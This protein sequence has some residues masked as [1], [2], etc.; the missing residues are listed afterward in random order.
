MTGVSRYHDEEVALQT[1]LLILAKQLSA[2]SISCSVL[3]DYL[4]NDGFNKREK[5][6]CTNFCFLVSE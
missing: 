4:R 3:R 1:Q 2:F 6:H 5:Q